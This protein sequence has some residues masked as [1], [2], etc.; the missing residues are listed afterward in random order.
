MDFVISIPGIM[1]ITVIMILHGI[2]MMDT[3]LAMILIR[4][5]EAKSQK[6]KKSPASTKIP[7]QLSDAPE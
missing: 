3:H 1:S 5:Q 4:D 7:E 6:K 2:P